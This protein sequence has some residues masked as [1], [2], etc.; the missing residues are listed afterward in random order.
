M[1]TSELILVL[2]VASVSQLINDA[3][4]GKC[5]EI[6]FLVLKGIV[7]SNYANPEYWVPKNRPLPFRLMTRMKIK[8]SYSWKALENGSQINIAIAQGGK[9]QEIY[10]LK[11]NISLFLEQNLFFKFFSLISRFVTSLPPPPPSFHRKEL[12]VINFFILFVYSIYHPKISSQKHTQ[13]YVWSNI[14]AFHGPEKLIQN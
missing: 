1:T 3:E 2:F 9:D 4:K 7:F 10:Y 13:S 11:I 12:L 5:V 8:L 14:C 6:F